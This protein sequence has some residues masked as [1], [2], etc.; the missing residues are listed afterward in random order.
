MKAALV[1][2]K[3]LVINLAFIG[4][5]LLS[6][7]VCRGLRAAYPN[8]RIDMLVIPLNE[9]I[10]AGNPYIDRV[11]IYD[12]RGRHKRLGELWKLIKELSREK[13]DLSLTMNFASRGAMFAW[14]IG[15][16][17]RVGYDRQHSGWFLTDIA[18]SSRERI[19]HETANHLEILKPLNI[20][21]TDTSLA[22][23]VQEADR[24]SLN[25]KKLFSNRPALAICPFGSYPKKSWVLSGYAELLKK[26]AD[27]WD[28]FL[29]GAAGDR[30]GL[31]QIAAASGREATILAGDLALG[32]LAAF[33]KEIKVLI[34]VDTGPMHLANA[35]GTPV[36]AL[37]GPTDPRIW[38]PRGAKDQVIQLDV[39]CSPCWG[40]G[41]CG[42]NR[43]MKE[44]SI[45]DVLRKVDLI[46]KTVEL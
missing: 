24:Q 23:R 40:K 2:Q 26:L 39:P 30:A 4:D 9:P 37:F 44:I 7:P 16:K 35:V 27:T 33:L 15:A 36:I 32:E 6:T 34:T 28:C 19:R 41:E 17:C 14:A 43:C 20:T 3:I 42:E 13:Y 25:Q 45:H 22:F 29:I 12:K 5:V 46:R 18:D 31:A 1:V 21:V 11:L 10:A 8:A 38:G